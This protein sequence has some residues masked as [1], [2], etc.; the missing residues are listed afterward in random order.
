MRKL[1]YQ[2]HPMQEILGALISPSA[3]KLV[4]KP[5]RLGS[6][7]RLRKFGVLSMFRRSRS[8]SIAAAIR[9]RI[10]SRTSVHQ[11]APFLQSRF[12]SNC[13]HHFCLVFRNV[14]QFF[15]G[16]KSTSKLRG[17]ILCTATTCR[18][19]ITV[20]LIRLGERFLQGCSSVAIHQLECIDLG[21]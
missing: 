18:I 16:S 15:A 10:S 12:F 3:P 5:W 11:D 1:L 6:T 19:E 4:Q 17:G 13:K 20:F 21:R 9:L 14:L 7:I 8:S 2:L